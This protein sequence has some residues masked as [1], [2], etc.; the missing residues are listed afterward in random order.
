MK[1]MNE[2]FNEHYINMQTMH[3]IT[4]IDCIEWNQCNRRLF[5]KHLRM[6]QNFLANSLSRLDFQCFRCKAPK[7]TNKTA[8]CIHPLFWDA[9]VIWNDETNYLSFI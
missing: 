8:D 1:E 2:T 5:A 7:N 6:E 4:E 9:R 3:E